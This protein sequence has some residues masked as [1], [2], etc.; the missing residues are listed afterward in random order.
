[1][2]TKKRNPSAKDWERN[3]SFKVE[4]VLHQK[5]RIW[6]MENQT[7]IKQALTDFMKGKVKMK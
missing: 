6:C 5:F 3:V 1:M 4:G 7:T 2:A